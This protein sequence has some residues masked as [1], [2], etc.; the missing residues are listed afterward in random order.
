MRDGS[1]APEAQDVGPLLKQVQF[2]KAVTADREVTAHGKAVANALV[3]V[4]WNRGD[5]YAGRVT[6]RLP[7][8]PASA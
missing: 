6:R 5:G 3:F 1:T 8:P 4:F 2:I 7:K